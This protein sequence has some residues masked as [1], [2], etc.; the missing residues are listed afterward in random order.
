MNEVEK[1]ISNHVRIF[2]ML[3]ASFVFFISINIVWVVFLLSR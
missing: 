3:V 2:L 1:V